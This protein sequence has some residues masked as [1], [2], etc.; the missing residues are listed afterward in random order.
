MFQMLGFLV[1]IEIYYLVEQI[2]LI[3]FLLRR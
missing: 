1:L 2:L 3:K